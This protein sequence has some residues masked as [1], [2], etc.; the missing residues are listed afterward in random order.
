MSK[1]IDDNGFWLIEN[2]PISK[3]GVF[4]YLGKTISP[5]LEPNKIYNVYR[6]FN[7]IS[8]EDTLKS[9]LPANQTGNCTRYMLMKA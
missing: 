3:E 4:P 7:E 8:K 6:P 9:I 1:I 2:N 5:Q